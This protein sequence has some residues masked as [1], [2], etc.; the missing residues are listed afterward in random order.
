MALYD[1]FFF[2]ACLKDTVNVDDVLVQRW[3]WKKSRFERLSPLPESPLAS[4]SLSQSLRVSRLDL[5]MSSARA[6]FKRNNLSHARGKMLVWI[7][8]SQNRATRVCLQKKKKR[9]I[10]S[11]GSDLRGRQRRWVGYHYR[12]WAFATSTKV[13]PNQTSTPFAEPTQESN[14]SSCYCLFSFLLSF[15]LISKRNK[16]GCSRSRSSPGTGRAELIDALDRHP[17]SC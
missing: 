7:I 6:T 10:E 2:S 13:Y 4:L 3:H 5:S 8:E 9:E 16:N 1:C 12:H 15:K 11:L 17:C 14:S